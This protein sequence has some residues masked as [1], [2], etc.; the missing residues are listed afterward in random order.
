MWLW[1]KPI[2]CHWKSSGHSVFKNWRMAPEPTRAAL[3][4]VFWTSVHA[5]KTGFTQNL[6]LAG[7]NF[8]GLF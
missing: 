2:A 8:S 1:K 4:S 6:Y 3:V 7:T 5:L